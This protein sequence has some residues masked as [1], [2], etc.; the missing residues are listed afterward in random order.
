MADI[1]ALTL[2]NSVQSD[3]QLREA[4]DLII[5][6]AFGCGNQ[7]KIPARKT[8]V[9]LVVKEHAFNPLRASPNQRCRDEALYVGFQQDLR[10]QVAQLSTYFS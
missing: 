9:D 4:L 5:E 6:S 8:R 3:P 10:I 2:E 1:L 7:G